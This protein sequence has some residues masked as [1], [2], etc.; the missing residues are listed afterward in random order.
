V[1][2]IDFGRTRRKIGDMVSDTE[3]GSG[4]GLMTGSGK[5]I[6]LGFCLVQN[7]K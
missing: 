5:P 1:G 7:I 2:N 6:V 4:R 3:I